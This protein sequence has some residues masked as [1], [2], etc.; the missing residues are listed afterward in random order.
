MFILS[1]SGPGTVAVEQIIL[2]GSGVKLLFFFFG[3][4]ILWVMN[5][6]GHG[7]NSLSLLH[8]V[9]ALSWNGGNLGD[10]TA[11]SAVTW[12]PHHSHVWS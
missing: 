3:T 6:I 10:L 4:W 7:G 11:D 1:Y 8:C 9:C 5:W 12:R 2:K